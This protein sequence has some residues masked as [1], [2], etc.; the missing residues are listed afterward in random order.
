MKD[1]LGDRM[2]NNYENITRYKLVRRMPVI[3]RIDM[4]AGHTFT[5][6]MK[7]PWDDI[8]HRSMNYT[9]IA[10]C[11]EIMNVKLA[12]TQSDEISFLLID[13]NKLTTEQFFDGNIQKIASITA[14]IATI[15][16]NRGFT[17]YVLNANFDKDQVVDADVYTKKI[18]TMTFDAR[19]F[20]IPESEVCNYFIWRQKDAERNSLQ[21]LAQSVFS[22]KELHK[23]TCKDMHE[24]LYQKDLNWNNY[25]AE[26]K[27]GC[28]AIK[29]NDG[30]W[31]VDTE[32]PI[33]T[34]D[35]NYV[36]SKLVVEEENV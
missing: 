26:F 14:S 15:N 3:I 28:C 36:E 30:V 11:Q 19:V 29:D 9:M 22:Q 31:K 4:R 6:G 27:R 2:K 5:R 17:K 35:R 25:S 13:Y 12:Y 32:I 8:F 34:Q 20:N 23:K 16:F 33:F 10:I 24:M 21:S 1:S 7:R 18:N